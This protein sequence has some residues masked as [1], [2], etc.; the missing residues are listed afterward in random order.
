MAYLL[1]RAPTE[2]FMTEEWQEK[3]RRIEKCTDCGQCIERCPYG[4]DPPSLLLKMYADYQ[5]VLRE[6]L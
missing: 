2:R 1:R 5:A 6:G 3:M 4:L